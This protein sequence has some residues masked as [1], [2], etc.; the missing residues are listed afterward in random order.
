MDPALLWLWCRWQLWL[1]FDPWPGSFHMLR[2]QALKIQKKKERKKENRSHVKW[3]YYKTNKK[4]RDEEIFEH[5]G[6]SLCGLR[7]Q[8][9]KCIHLFKLTKSQTWMMCGFLTYQL[10]LNKAGRGGGGGNPNHFSEERNTEPAIT[11]W[12]QE[13]SNSSELQDQPI[14]RNKTA[15]PRGCRTQEQWGFACTHW[16]QVA[17]C[18]KLPQ[19]EAPY[20]VT[21]SKLHCN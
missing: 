14:K 5:D 9:H 6:Y 16:V 8:S 4:Q 17:L 3:F 15:L 20:F 18:R 13:I 7:W 19:Q 1:R 2:V 10:Y 11:W 21:L 12:G